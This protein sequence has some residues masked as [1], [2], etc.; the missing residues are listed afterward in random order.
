MKI[1]SYKSAMENII[2]NKAGSSFLNIKIDRLISIEHFF[3][4]YLA[5]LRPTLSHSQG[6]SLTYL[7]L[8]SGFYLFCPE[9]HGEPHNEVGLLSPAEYLVGFEP[10]TLRC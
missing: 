10:G 5:A 4:S 7:M 6:S 2:V 3:N 1:K 8:I 9:S